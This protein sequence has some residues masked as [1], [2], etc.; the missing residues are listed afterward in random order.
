MIQ[1][2]LSDEEQ[3]MRMPNYGIQG[4][5]IAKPQPG[6]LQQLEGYAKDKVTSAALSGAE[7]KV[8]EMAAPKL[9]E[10]GLTQGAMTTA[11]PYV[12]AGILAGKALGFFNRGGAV[13]DQLIGPLAIRK[14]KYKQDGGKIEVEATMGE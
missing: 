1:L 8:I 10:M 5:P 9:A 14:I 13:N 3:R 4:A 12:G 2:A 11:M 7:E 6:P